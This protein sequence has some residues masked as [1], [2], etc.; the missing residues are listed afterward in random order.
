MASL[1]V[2]KLSRLVHDDEGFGRPS[3]LLGSRPEDFIGNK[4]M[5]LLCLAGVWT[6]AQATLWVLCGLSGVLL[7]L[8]I[9]SGLS[10]WL[11]RTRREEIGSLRHAEV[12]NGGLSCLATETMQSN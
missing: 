4:V 1:A 2:W 9:V 11:Q 10:R 3:G 12:E 7:N 5:H 8:L 6:S